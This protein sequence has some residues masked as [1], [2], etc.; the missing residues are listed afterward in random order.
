[1]TNPT[2]NLPTIDG[3]ELARLARAGVLAEAGTIRRDA[4]KAL[5]ALN[6]AAV[7]A[8]A[9]AGAP[10]ESAAVAVHAL[11]SKLTDMLR[12]LSASSEELQNA[13]RA[14]KERLA[15]LVAAAAHRSIEIVSTLEGIARRIRFGESDQ[16]G[17]RDRLKAA[18]LSGAELDRA[19]APFDPSE[20]QAERAA[21]MVE[22]DALGQFLQTRDAQHLPA[23]FADEAA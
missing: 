17:K 1:M 11:K 14:E 7:V 23:G 20:L 16:N 15:P 10:G 3:A 5:A 22:Q 19:A 13:Q 8:L 2:P 18:G 4:S 9:M 12:A 6:D 21:L